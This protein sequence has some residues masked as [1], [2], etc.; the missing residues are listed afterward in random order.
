MSGIPINEQR[1][2]IADQYAT[3]NNLGLNGINIGRT[4]YHLQNGDVGG[5]GFVANAL[6][7]GALR[8]GSVTGDVTTAGTAVNTGAV[9]ATVTPVFYWVA[10]GPVGAA[11]ASAPSSAGGTFSVNA[12]A[13]GTVTVQYL[14]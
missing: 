12:S 5:F 4:A 14:Y 8:Y 11:V 10:S 6:Q 7:A 13:T 9:P 3:A 1:A 2:L